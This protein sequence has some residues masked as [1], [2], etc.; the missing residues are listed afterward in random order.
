MALTARDTGGRFW[1]VMPTMLAGNRV[2]VVGPYAAAALPHRT[3]RPAGDYGAGRIPGGFRGRTPPGGGREM[4]GGVRYS[5]A[6]T[7]LIDAAV[8]LV[9]AWIGVAVSARA[10]T[11][12]TT[13]R[14]LDPLA[15]ALIVGAALPLAVRRVW[16]LV[17][18]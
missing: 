14:Q 13:A 16:P 6:G 8:A 15:Y 5:R 10:G 18:L 17:T 2:R 3:Y 12:Q 11:W 9:V 4:I 1:S 7:L